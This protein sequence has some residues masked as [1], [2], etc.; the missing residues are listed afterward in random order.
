MP[1]EVVYGS[2]LPFGNSE[3][4]GSGRAIVEVR[5]GPD[6]YV[7]IVTKC[8]DS[9]TGERLV[10]DDENNNLIH[11][12]DGFYVD[13]DRR[14]INELIRHLRRARDRAFGRDE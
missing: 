13:L 9:Q 14:E 11:Y 3:D 10:K 12:T 5:W 1:K 6:E 8:I 7:Q 2:K 4:P